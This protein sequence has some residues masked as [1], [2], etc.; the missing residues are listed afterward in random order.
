MR[1]LFLLF[2]WA[3]CAAT[4]QFAD[5]FERGSL[6]G[7]TQTPE[8]HWSA[9]TVSALSGNYSLKHVFNHSGTA[10]DIA[11]RS[12]DGLQMNGGNTTWRFLLRH[13]YNPS[14][15]NRWAAFL[16]SNAAG[17]EWKSKGIYEGYALGV[18][19]AAPTNSDTL[20]L[21]AVQNNSFTIIRKTTVNWEKDLRTTGAGAIEV[22]RT[23]DGQWSINVATTGSFD[24]LQPAAEPALHD[25]YIEA[26][27]FGLSY[28][29]TATA[30]MLLWIDDISV[31]FERVIF[32]TKISAATQQAPDKIQVSFTQ[33]I[34]AATVG[35]VA[36]Y[37]FTNAACTLTPVSAEAVNSKEVLLTFENPLPRGEA[38]LGVEKLLDENNNEVTGE[39]TVTV[40]YLLYGD[41][42]INEIMASPAPS[43]GLPEVSYIELYNRLDVPVPLNGWKIEYNA[44]AGN[45]GAAT[46]PA[47]GYLILCTPA[48][49][50]D[51][52]A[53]GNATNVSYISSL[54]KSGKT[55]QLKNDEGQLL[56]RV[57]YS[58]QWF[59]DDDQRAG[60]RSLE[61]I[62]ADNLSETTTNWK[63]ST[64]ERGGTPGAQNT[65]QAHHPDVEAPFAAS[66][67]MRDNNRLLL[68]FNE[69]FDRKQAVNTT[70]Y[71]VNKGIGYPVVISCADSLFLQVELQFDQDFETGIL[72]ELTVGTPFCDLAGN[73]PDETPY[74]F[75][76]LFMPAGGDVVINELLFNPP[77]NGA[78]FVEIYNRSNKTFD[79]RQMRLAH[80]D[81]NNDVAAIQT[82]PQQYY[83][84][85]RE[86]AVFTTGLEAVRQFYFVSFP[87][88]VI[89]L[90][91]LPSYPNEGGCVVL[92]NEDG[93]VVD[94]FLYSEKMHSGFI[95]NP[96]GISLER[97]NPAGSASEPANWQSAAQDA[98]FATPTSRNSQFNDSAADRGQAF[99]LRHTTFSPDG[100]GYQDV[101]FIDYNLPEGGYEASLTV[102]DI[103][104]R[105]VRSLGKNMWLGSS[106]SLAWDGAR[107]NGQRALSGLFIVFIQCYSVRGDVAVYKLPCA[108]ALR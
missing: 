92:L 70:A 60:G 90:K 65:A 47:N 77:A 79:L 20:T 57:T 9:S 23:G 1:P 103:Q 75:G 46:L 37:T 40:F 19:M 64:D 53:Y 101:L 73:V 68:L 21:Y 91:N 28:Q 59:T 106:G 95:S 30:D 17:S 85:P 71:R 26:N 10:T 14:G 44:T 2:L 18:N 100:D 32:P 107:D 67:Q 29:Y 45:I 84:H 72:Y 61:K 105:V 63:A 80:R 66:V 96:K 3:P 24:D 74:T 104:G 22:V 36:N 87:E 7:W 42:V 62:D 13:G 25:K 50:E 102:Y 89:V 86:Y 27:Y 4:A 34:D 93:A 78:D 6:D 49:V 16:F 38:T 35:E 39:T 98:G 48:A 8:S 52:H 33:H 81:K 97:V 88:K 31:S 12:L 5:N 54:S 58:D 41:V 15:T 11:Y 94:E 108:V 56:A 82:I 69:P 51:M 55:L 99:S 83:L 76:R 43:I